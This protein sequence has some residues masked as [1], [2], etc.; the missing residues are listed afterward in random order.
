MQRGD[1]ANASD[2]TR[3]SIEV[4]ALWHAVEMGTD[5]NASRASVASGQRHGHVADCVNRDFEAGRLGGGSHDVM[6]SL[7]AGA[8][9]VAHD[10]TPAA[11]RPAKRV[12][13]A[14]GEVEIGLNCVE[15]WMSPA[16]E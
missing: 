8:V 16:P 3:R 14:G 1:R 10:P 15:N 7:L 11:C 2:H 13:Q 6:R 5:D 9:A 12:E 4:A